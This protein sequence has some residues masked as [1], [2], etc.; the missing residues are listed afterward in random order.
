[1][2]ITQRFGTTLVQYVL[3]FA[4]LD[5]LCRVGK[6]VALA[7]AVNVRAGLVTALLLLNSVVIFM[8][9]FPH[10]GRDTIIFMPVRYHKWFVQI[11]L[12]ILLRDIISCKS[13]VQI[14]VL[15]A[16]QTSVLSAYAL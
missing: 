14:E 5:M 2:S 15:L 8:K 6:R 4:A 3:A 7:F 9:H 10:E 13:F 11:V 16:L 1:M 12:Q